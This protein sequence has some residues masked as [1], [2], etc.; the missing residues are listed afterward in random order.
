MKTLLVIFAVIAGIIGLIFLGLII[1][2]NRRRPKFNNKGF[3]LLEKKLLMELFDLF[4]PD[5]SNKLKKQLEYFEPKRKW[6]Q[7]WEKSMS[8]ELYGDNDNPLSEELRYNRRDESKLAIIRFKVNDEKYAIEFDNYDGRLWGW[9]IRPNP[10]SIMKVDAVQIASK[11]IHTDPSSF[12]HPNFKKEKLKSAPAFTGWLTKLTKMD[13]IKASW[14]PI[15]PKFLGKYTKRIDSKLPDGYLEL[16]EQTE[17]LDFEQYRILGVSEIYATGLDDGN[18]YH[19]AEFDDGIMAIKEGEQ[20]G[21]MYYCHYSGL[22]DELSSD[23][24]KELIERIKYDT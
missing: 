6:R 18:Y 13:N 2:A 7:Y 9:K 5:L 4:E 14:Y 8:V 12:A 22:L 24:E 10:K 21:T 1:A 20:T 15:G 23:F 19:L 16:I 3:T 17:G 11:K